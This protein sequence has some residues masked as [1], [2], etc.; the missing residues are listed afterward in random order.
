MG[1]A[2]TNGFPQ[3]EGTA[4]ATCKH[5]EGDP[6]R[7]DLFVASELSAE[8]SLGL[9]KFQQET[10]LN[11]H[12]KGLSKDEIG[13]DN[14]INLNFGAGAHLQNGL[15][16]G[17]H[18][19]YV[20]WD[21][22]R[23]TSTAVGGP[24]LP[25]MIDTIFLAG[26]DDLLSKTAPGSSEANNYFTSTVAHELSHGV[27]VWHH[28]ENGSRAVHW[29]ADDTGQ[30]WETTSVDALQHPVTGTG[31]PI[32]VFSE[33]QDPRTGTPTS[34]W[35][36][37]LLENCAAMNST[38]PP[39]SSGRSVNLGNRV[40]SGAVKLN[41]QL[42]GD[43]ECYMRYDNAE[44]YIPS[45][46]P[47]VRYFEVEEITG[48]HL[49][50]T[51]DGTGVNDSGHPT[52]LGGLSRYGPAD[53]QHQRGNCLSQINVNDLTDPPRRDAPASCTAN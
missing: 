8:E 29:Y 50:D 3:Q 39:N 23:G 35:N 32:Q 11:V 42:S 2:R 20:R 9:A 25:R 7:K 31:I 19:L 13:T 17:Q 18:A 30:V 27:D 48:Q 26:G 44:A 45:G 4:G 41:G 33:D 53:T 38:C 15:T 12:Y 36:L 28:G 46:F 34:A 43:Q 16:K 51:T 6:K 40:C 1:C 22:E 52:G 47:N 21:A 14:L 49:T 5:V 10:K 24:G 37:G